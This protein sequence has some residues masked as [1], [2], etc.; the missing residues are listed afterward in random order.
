M[1]GGKGKKKRNYI[2]IS[3]IKFK[4]IGGKEEVREGGSRK[5]D[6][7]CA[8]LLD[9]SCQKLGLLL[10][11]SREQHT[12]LPYLVPGSCGCIPRTDVSRSVTISHGAFTT[13]VPC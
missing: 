11:L 2:R 9:R 1:K 12:C 5:R 3:K 4:T 6:P 8:N 10:K 13:E 7:V